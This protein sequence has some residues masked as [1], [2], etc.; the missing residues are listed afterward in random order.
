MSHL[1]FPIAHRKVIRTANLLERLFVEE[2]RRT[3]I[4]PNF[5]HGERPVLKLMYAALIRGAERWRGIHMTVFESRQLEVIRQELDEEHRRQ[6]IAGVTIVRGQ[7]PLSRLQ[8]G[9]DLTARDEFDSSTV[10]EVHWELAH[11]RYRASI[12]LKRPGFG[13]GVLITRLDCATPARAGK[14]SNEALARRS[15]RPKATQAASA[16]RCRPP[17]VT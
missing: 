11:Y 6:H 9:Q 13:W 1:R 16:S 10:R 14:C 4:I 17:A 7:V 2:R 12:G 3:K 15:Y 5:F 8:Q